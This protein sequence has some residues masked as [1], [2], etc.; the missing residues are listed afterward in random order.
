MV[1]TSELVLSTFTLG[2]LRTCQVRNV[3][4]LLSLC[5]NG[6]SVLSLGYLATPGSPQL[7]LLAMVFDTQRLNLYLVLAKIPP[8]C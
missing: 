3:R 2:S 7:V 1:F 8:S 4:D 6:G 5:C